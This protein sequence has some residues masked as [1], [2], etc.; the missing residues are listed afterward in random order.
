M[1]KIADEESHTQRDHSHGMLNTRVFD[2]INH[3]LGPL[4]VDLFGSRLTSLLPV[5]FS[6]RPD[7][8]A[9]ATAS[10]FQ[11]WSMIKGYANPPWVLVGQ[12]LA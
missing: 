11:N 4:K 1:R 2:K 7:P 10:L 5:F 8:L 6:W 9:K 12:V 3:S